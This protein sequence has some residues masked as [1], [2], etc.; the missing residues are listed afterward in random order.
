M[1]SL[2]MFRMLKAFQNVL[3]R[4]AREKQKVVHTVETPAYTISGEKMLLLE[5]VKTGSKIPFEEVFEGVENRV[6][7]IFV[8][9]SMLELVQE[10]Q[11]RIIIGEGYNNFWIANAAEPELLL[12]G[13]EN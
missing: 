1:Q 10:Q 9:L 7:A 5:K 3:D 4:L 2:T 11:L 8:L 13:Q 12:N 6:H